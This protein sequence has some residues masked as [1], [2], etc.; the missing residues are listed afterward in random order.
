[1]E[2]EHCNLPTSLYGLVTSL[3]ELIKEIQK[4]NLT[5]LFSISSVQ[6][7]S[8]H[9]SIPPVP[10]Y[11]L[12]YFTMGKPPLVVRHCL[13][14]TETKVMT[15]VRFAFVYSSHIFNAN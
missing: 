10:H 14:L 15:D 9:F 3:I 1:M 6:L 11:S 12:Q 4:L 13:L 2:L 5:F 8:F 7:E